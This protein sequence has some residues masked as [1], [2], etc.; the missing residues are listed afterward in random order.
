M[1]DL[2]ILPQK[3]KRKEKRSIN[4]YQMAL[5]FAKLVLIFKCI[6]I[7]SATCRID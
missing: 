5:C 6:L 7:A 2:Q 1:L 3:K 4:Y